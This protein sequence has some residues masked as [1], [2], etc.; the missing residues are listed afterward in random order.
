[1]TFNII[2][3]AA[4]GTQLHHRELEGELN[5]IREYRDQATDVANGLRNSH[6]GR[7][8]ITIRNGGQIIAQQT[9]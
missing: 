8:Q 7:K 4:D 3:T 2:T 5:A 6:D 1:M 9:I